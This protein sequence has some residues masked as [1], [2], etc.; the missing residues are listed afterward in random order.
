MSAKPT[1]NPDLSVEFKYECLRG[2]KIA[3]ICGGGVG[4]IETPKIA[5]EL[6][7][8]G[9]Q[10]QIFP[11]QMSLNFV[12]KMALEWASACEV[13]TD[14]SG[15]A[16]HINTFD[17]ALVAPA[18]TDTL[19]KISHGIADDL[20]HTLL[21]SIV[22]Q[23]KPIILCPSMHSSLQNSNF[24]QQNVQKMKENS[25]IYFIESRHEEGKFK[26]RTFNEVA[27]EVSYILNSQNNIFKQTQTVGISY[28]GT[29]VFIDKARRITNASTGALGIETMLYLY[30]LGYKVLAFECSVSEKS[31]ALEHVKKI[32][33]LEFQELETAF[34][35][36]GTTAE[37]N[38]GAFFHLAAVSDYKLK[39][40]NFKKIPS[41]LKELNLHL[42][43]TQKLIALSSF[44]FIKY[45]FACKLTEDFSDTSLSAALKFTDTNNLTGC[46][47]N[48]TQA[49]EFPEQHTGFLIE[50][51]TLQP[52][53]IVSKKTIAIEFVNLLEKNI[54]SQKN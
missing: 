19:A 37:L 29:C 34:Q 8:F 47:W 2:K 15:L 14:F 50:N 20:P 26:S 46:F 35:K 27:L 53:K 48:S 28:G 9:A 1:E 44:Q 17:A 18:T 23:K 16:P 13:L 41:N 10:V 38:V 6:R 12:G 40:S 25:F 54:A 3:I 11:T 43:P 24:T 51:K 22:G 39:E 42:L 33:T 31:P 52:K 7:R 36:I 5:R 21:Q 45:K 32:K 30:A 49:F 4:A